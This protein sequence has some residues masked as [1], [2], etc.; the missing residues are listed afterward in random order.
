[1]NPEDRQEQI[2]VFAQKKVLD[3]VGRDNAKQIS[4]DAINKHY[5]ELD[6][7]FKQSHL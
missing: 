7:Q 6:N 3:K 2:R 4:R 5:E 1:M